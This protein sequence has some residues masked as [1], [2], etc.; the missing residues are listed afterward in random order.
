MT[1]TNLAQFV[2]YNNL[3]GVDLDWEDNAAMENGTGE[4]WLIDCTI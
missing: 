4:Q 3:D 2:I 1:A